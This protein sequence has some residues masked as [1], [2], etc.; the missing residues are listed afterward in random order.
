MEF[1]RD[2][3]QEHGSIE[4]DLL[5]ALDEERVTMAQI[6]SMTT[7]ELET[8]ISENRYPNSSLGGPQQ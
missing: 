8:A 5:D 1:L 2:L 6:E 4:P 7:D 3:T